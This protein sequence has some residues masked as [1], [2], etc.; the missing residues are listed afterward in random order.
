MYSDHDRK[1]FIAEALSF[2]KSLGKIRCPALE[3][4]VVTFGNSGF[5]HLI[6]KD[7]KNR[8]FNEVCW[9]IELLKYAPSLIKDMSTTYSKTI[10]QNKIYGTISYFSMI[11][12]IDKIKV[13]IIL[14][15]YGTD[16]IHFLSIMTM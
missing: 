7:R 5:S 16:N 10:S 8:P 4:K 13:K 3:N 2:Y 11:N 14:R 12:S 1:K 15:Q 6:R 9:R